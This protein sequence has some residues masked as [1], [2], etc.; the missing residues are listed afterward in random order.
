MSQQVKI[1]RMML[2]E[3]M[4]KYDHNER[5]DR[6]LEYLNEVFLTNG[7]TKATKDIEIFTKTQFFAPYIKRWRECSRNNVRFMQKYRD[8]LGHEIVFPEL[9]RNRLISSD[10]PSTS[11]RGRPSK[12]FDDCSDV[13]KRRKTDDL[14]KTKT[15]GEL[16]YAAAMKLREEGDT[17]S[18][19]LLVESTSTSPTRSRR[20]L[21]KWRSPTKQMTPLSP[22]EAVALIIRLHL[23]KQTYSTL[24]KVA[25]MHGHELYPSYHNVLEAKK[26]AYP[27]G[28]VVSENVCEV[29]LQNL[30]HKTCESILKMTEMP[31]TNK[32]L[33]L[34]C[35]W[36]FDGSSGFS[37]YKHIPGTSESKDTSEGSIFMT[38]LVPLRLVEEGTDNILWKNP[39]PSST[40]FCR[41]VRLQWIHETAEISKQ[42]E[43]YINNQIPN[44]EPYSYGHGSINFSLALTMVDGKVCN[45]LSD[46]SAMKC[47][48][49]NAT[50]SQLNEIKSLRKR[51]VQ[52][53]MYRFGLSVLH[54][55]IRFF[56][57]IL[58]ISYRLELKTW[59]V[60]K[61]HKT[62]LEQRKQLIQN[63]FRQR[64][65]LI[66]DV[67]KQGFGTSNDGNTARKFFADPT[68]AAEI[69]GVDEELIR[70]FGVILKTINSGY[71]IKYAEFDKYCLETAERYIHMYNWYYMPTSVHKIL[72][73]GAD[74]I[75]NAILPIGELSEEAQ[76]TKN[77][78]IRRFREHHT[79]KS[80]KI[81]NN[82]DLFKRLLLSS[83]PYISSFYK[84]DKKRECLKDPEVLNLLV[85]PEKPEEEETED[86][87]D[88]DTDEEF[89][90]DESD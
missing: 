87:E 26:N 4:I 62:E 80:S 43:A 81:K 88:F 78:E 68:L 52:P 40:R 69:T 66:V 2:H 5:Q 28:I 14:R 82:E 60:P 57:C 55:Y 8:W 6:V 17:A 58:H 29:G 37:V 46:T 49:C 7:D 50:I 23:S 53:E 48:I 35:K 89:G 11:S 1:T 18:A 86:D 73:H 41:P 47:Y 85:I 83:D 65:G 20:I 16:V 34:I 64:M 19:Q 72:I 12:A 59:K 32:T 76:E 42:E 13:I 38:S 44:L 45:A 33:Q 75:H 71:E 25:N 79:R 77:K 3:I 21:H 90:S 74:V 67:P 10:V 15:S 61:T 63:A 51:P 24:R 56:E 30:L 27:S 36:G 39:R 70:R 54:A 22:E 31:E 9:V 84:S